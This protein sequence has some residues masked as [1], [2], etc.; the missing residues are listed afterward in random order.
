M[1]KEKNYSAIEKILTPHIQPFSVLAS[2][3]Y[4]LKQAEIRKT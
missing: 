4:F 3:N 1:F 2:V